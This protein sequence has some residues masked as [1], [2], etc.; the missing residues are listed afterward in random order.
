M[1]GVAAELRVT[2]DPS[3]GT[4]VTFAIPC[5]IQVN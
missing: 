1:Y 2:S 3:S 5:A 4:T